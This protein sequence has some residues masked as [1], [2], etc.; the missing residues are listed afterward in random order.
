MGYETKA[1]APA[2]PLNIERYRLGTSFW[3]DRP[4]RDAYREYTHSSGMF[5]FRIKFYS[6]GTFRLFVAN[7]TYDTIFTSV[8][9]A[10]FVSDYREIETT[11]TDSDNSIKYTLYGVE[12]GPKGAASQESH[13][14]AY[15]A[16]NENIYMRGTLF[17]QKRGGSVVGKEIMDFIIVSTNAGIEKNIAL[18]VR[19]C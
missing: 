12:S 19:E 9:T 3:V 8:D 16:M 2:N 15:F 7:N 6:S 11:V 14:S 10:M 13:I 18:Y 1:T 5:T 4:Y 17:C